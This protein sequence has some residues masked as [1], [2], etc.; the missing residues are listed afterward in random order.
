MA[1]AQ[2]AGRLQE[3][4][5]R[6]ATDVSRQIAAG[7]AS[8]D[9]LKGQGKL[10]SMQAQMQQQQQLMGLAQADKTASAQAAAQAEQNKWGAISS[11]ISA[12][13]GFFG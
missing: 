8:V 3:M 7:Q 9:Q 2:Q 5:A 1:A 4:E 12:I 6:G 10:Q 13:G 11:G